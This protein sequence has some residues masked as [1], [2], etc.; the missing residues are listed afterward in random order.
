MTG[1]QSPGNRDDV[2]WPFLL[3]MMDPLWQPLEIHL[4]GLIMTKD[5]KG[6]V[7][8]EPPLT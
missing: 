4:V 3:P 2:Q 6:S 8:E 1:L 7:V 5:D